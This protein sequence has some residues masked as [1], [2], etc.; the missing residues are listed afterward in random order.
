MVNREVGVFSIYD[1]SCFTKLRVHL[2]CGA[3]GDTYVQICC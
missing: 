3:N 1:H 2:P